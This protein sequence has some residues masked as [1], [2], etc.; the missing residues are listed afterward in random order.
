[1]SSV[2]GCKKVVSAAMITVVTRKIFLG[3]RINPELKKALEEIGDA[4]ERSVSQI[5]ELILREGV[6]SYKKEGTK[7]LQRSTSRQKKQQPSQ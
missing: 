1:M 3:I 4:E 7:Y 5:S 2:F 6:E